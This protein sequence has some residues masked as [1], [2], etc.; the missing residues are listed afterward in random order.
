MGLKRPEQV[1][2]IAEAISAMSEHEF[3]RR[4]FAI[5]QE[6][7]DFPGVG[8]KRCVIS[9]R[10]Q[11]EIAGVLQSTNDQS[12]QDAKDRSLPLLRAVRFHPSFY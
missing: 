4:Y 5:D 6:S 2:D 3:R 10:G 9:I 8:F 1:C 12:Q 7:Y 11:P